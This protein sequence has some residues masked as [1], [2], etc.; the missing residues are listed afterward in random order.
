MAATPNRISVL[1]QMLAA[2]ADIRHIS[3][4]A[5]HRK[6]IDAN[7]PINLNTVYRVLHHLDDA[8]IVRRC[9]FG[10]RETL[11]ELS[12]AT[13]HYHICDVDTGEVVDFD[14]EAMRQL[15]SAVARKHG[16]TMH[17]HKLTLYVKRSQ[18]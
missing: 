8:G 17:D 18:T 9:K 16:F 14:S 2:Q 5:L 7:T 6:L 12:Q 11:F 10:S 15:V 4:T 3:A 13:P 1:A